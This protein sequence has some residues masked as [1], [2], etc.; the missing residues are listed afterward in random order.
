MREPHGDFENQP[1]ATD[2]I[3]F[4]SEPTKSADWAAGCGESFDLTGLPDSANHVYDAI[5]TMSRRIEDLARELN[6]LG[7]FGDDDG[8]RAA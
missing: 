2:P 8:P 7:Y 4:P 6:C 1:T 5:D 3:L